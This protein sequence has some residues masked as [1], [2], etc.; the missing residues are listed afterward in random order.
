MHL[1]TKTHFQQEQIANKENQLK[2]RLRKTYLHF[3]CFL[4]HEVTGAICHFEKLK[5]QWITSVELFQ[6]HFH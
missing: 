6:H 1:M 3:H 4:N 5:Q 2:A